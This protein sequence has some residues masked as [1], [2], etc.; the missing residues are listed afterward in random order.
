M[1]SRDRKNFDIG[2]EL[3]FKFTK[4][5]V[6]GLVFFVVFV[7]LAGKADSNTAR[8]VVDTLAPDVLV[9]GGVNSDVFGAHGLL[10]ELADRIHATRSSSLESTT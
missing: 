2:V 3:Q 9:D 7:D 5:M 1:E 4:R 10:S 6:Y 8:N